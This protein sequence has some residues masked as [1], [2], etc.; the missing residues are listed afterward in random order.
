[1]AMRT[2]G[3]TGIAV[4]ELGFG[5]LE[6]G[7]DWAADVNANPGHLS[8]EQAAAVLNGVLDRGINFIDTAPA[9]WFSEEYIGNAIAGR[10]EDFVLA[11]KV[12]E[13][14]D[15][16]GSFYDYSAE[17]TA[18]FIDRSLQ[19]L[20]TD[21]IDLL[22]IH[23]ASVEVLEKGETLTAMQAAVEAGKVRHCGMTGTV[24]AALRAVEIGGFATVQVPFNLLDF[25]A[26]ASLFPLCKAKGIGVIIMRGLAGGK[27]TARYTNLADESLKSR[28]AALSDKARDLYPD[29]PDPLA[30]MALRFIKYQAA[31]STIIIGT[32]RLEA[33]D[34]NLGYLSSDL[35]NNEIRLFEELLDQ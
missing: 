20:R 3:G 17:A 14:C 28:I 12:G 9:Y 13:H 21:Y 8:V 31:V 19:R 35:D 5:A 22:Q 29:R 27:L 33:V 6:I 16:Q 11:T 7:R 32:R 1:M 18:Q 23:S 30:C 2:L 10:R 15:K 26:A 25:S 34:T 24:E 4:S